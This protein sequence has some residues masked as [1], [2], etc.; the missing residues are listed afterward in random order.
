MAGA[1]QSVSMARPYAAS[2]AA[3]LERPPP[4]GTEQVKAKSK[5]W[6]STPRAATSWAMP[7][8]RLA[9]VPFSDS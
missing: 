2:T 4:E 9:D 5:P 7:R 6:G 8:T 3:E 1:P